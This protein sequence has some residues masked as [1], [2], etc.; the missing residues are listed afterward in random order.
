MGTQ[1]TQYPPEGLT[2]QVQWCIAVCEMLRRQI[3][4][5][6][7]GGGSTTLPA[8]YIGYGD[9]SNQLTGDTNFTYDPVGGMFHVTF[10]NSNI[11]IIDDG[12]T[13]S[14]NIV[15]GSEAINLY[16]SLIQLFNCVPT[17]TNDAAA[18][19]GG[20]AS[21]NLYKSTTSGSTFL[22]IVP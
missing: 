12:S 5:S 7:G 8:T 4:N 16:N 10:S 9:N 11:D 6:S 15:A 14:I 21:G 20:L 19:A 3:N 1:P 22:K 2:A 18:V 13:S 17:Y